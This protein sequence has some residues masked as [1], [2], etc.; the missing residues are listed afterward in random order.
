MDKPLNKYFDHTLLKPEAT[1]EDI[2]KLCEEAKEYDFYSVC[3]NSIY[4]PLAKEELKGTDVKVASVVGFPLGAMATEAKAFETEWAVNNGADEIDM[5][6]PIGLLKEGKYLDVGRDIKEVRDKAKNAILKVILETCLL[7]EEEIIKACA[8]S[9]ENGAD[10]V[11]T[12]TGFSTKGADQKIVRMMKEEVRGKAK[13]KASGGIRD[14]ET[15]IMMIEA[16]ADRL[17]A[18][19]SVNIMKEWNNR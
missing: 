16:G 9:V 10:F 5:V 18:S 1:Q 13:V 15:A 19:A 6:L 2:I 8:I 7:T 11:K 3:V 14:L 4:V 12:S 17:G